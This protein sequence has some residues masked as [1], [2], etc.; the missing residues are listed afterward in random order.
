MM[1][2]HVPDEGGDH[3]RASKM[4]IPSGCCCE[5]VFSMALGPCIGFEASGNTQAA[6]QMPEPVII[7][8]MNGKVIQNNRRN[9]PLLQPFEGQR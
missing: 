7:R 1:E 2:I 3:V 5:E 6:G 4:P 9:S 8:N